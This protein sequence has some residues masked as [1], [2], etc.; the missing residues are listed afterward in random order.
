MKPAKVQLEKQK[1]TITWND[2]TKSE[3]DLLKLRNK[4]PCATCLAEKEKQSKTYF[5]LFNE[6]QLK[7]TDIKQV[8]SYALS[9][10]WRDGHNT[11]IYEYT[12]LK[13]LA[14]DK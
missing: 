5:H 1:L 7:V 9:I 13:K 10:S 8:G 2:G 4:C 11:G 12:F 14:N 6:N 3:I